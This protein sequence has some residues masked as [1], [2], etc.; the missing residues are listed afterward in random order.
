MAKNNHILFSFA[1][2]FCY[3]YSQSKV[4]LDKYVQWIAILI[5]RDQIYV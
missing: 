2:Q 5:I 1:M 4:E 3:D